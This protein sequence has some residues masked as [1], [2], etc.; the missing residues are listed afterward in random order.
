MS[1][2]L[3]KQTKPAKG[4]IKAA[5]F[6][7]DGTVSTL[8]CGWESVMQPLMVE[9]IGGGKRDDAELQNLVAAYIDA[10]TGIQTVYQMKWLA[11]QV[12]KF[13]LASEVHDEWWYKDEYNR[14]LMRQVSTRIDGL[15]SGKLCR[16]DYI[17]SGSVEFLTALKNSG[18]TIYVASGT[19]HDDVVN[20]IGVL[21]LTDCFTYIQGAPSRKAA[22]SKEAVIKMIIDEKNLRGDELVLVGDGKVEIALGIQNGAYALGIASDEEMRRGVNPVKR[23]RLITAGACAIVGDFDENAALLELLGIA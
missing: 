8:R 11:E 12:A 16:D 13:G 4:Q 5:I 17:I 6:D 22:C 19:D 2:E 10:S 23:N 14:R 20:E 3:I 1:I 7:F 9:M 15:Q 21:G 18:V